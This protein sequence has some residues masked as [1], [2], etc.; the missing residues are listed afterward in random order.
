MSSPTLNY[1][2]DQ[3][4][5][6]AGILFGPLVGSMITTV[7]SDLVGPISEMIHSTTN[8]PA[9][10]KIK[11]NEMIKTIIK[12]SIMMA[13]L[14]ILWRGLNYTAKEIIKK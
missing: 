14:Y 3:K 9:D 10:K 11:W 8:N 4:I 7:M 6:S 13:V 1:L 2:A 12:Y 5:L